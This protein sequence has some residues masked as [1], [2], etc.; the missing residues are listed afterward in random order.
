MGSN[1]SPPLYQLSYHENSAFIADIVDGYLAI[2]ILWSGDVPATR[3]M[4]GTLA[5]FVTLYLDY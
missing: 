1:Y 5:S 4:Y 2:I 3:N